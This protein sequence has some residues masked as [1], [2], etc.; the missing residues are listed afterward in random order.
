MMKRYYEVYNSLKEQTLR[1]KV[2]VCE[3]HFIKGKIELTRKFLFNL[4]K[5]KQNP[6]HILLKGS[7]F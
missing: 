1:G 3:S 5:K 4:V 6:F 7:Y 2:Y